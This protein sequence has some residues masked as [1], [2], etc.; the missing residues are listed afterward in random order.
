ME[1][2]DIAP[3]RLLL[4]AHKLWHLDWLVLGTGSLTHNDANAMT[5]GW[6]S[7]GTMWSRPFVM[8]VIRPQRHSF[9]LM[10]KYRDF[11][12]CALDENYKDAHKIFGGKS[13]RDINKL[14]LSQLTPQACSK[15]DAPGFQEAILCLECRCMYHS[16]ID[17]SGFMDPS[18][19]S[20]YPG[21][22]YHHVYYG[23]ILAIRGTE[24]FV[25]SL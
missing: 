21:K 11:S 20:N 8:V 13:G 6:G 17:P 24:A 1:L 22:D 15:I 9:S 10:E 18:L 16:R 23:E 7:F 19:E 14:A 12:I 2:I 5:I 3:E 4:Q 25:G